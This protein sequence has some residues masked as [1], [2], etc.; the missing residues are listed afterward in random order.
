M[1]TV[2]SWQFSKLYSLYNNSYFWSLF[3]W[4]KT[5]NTCVHIQVAQIYQSI[6][7]SR[8][9][10]LVPF[11]DAFQLE[12]NI[13]DAARH[14]DLQVSS[15]VI[16]VYESCMDSCVLYWMK[17]IWLTLNPRKTI[18]SDSWRLTRLK[19]DNILRTDDYLHFDVWFWFRSTTINVKSSRSKKLKWNLLKLALWA[20]VIESSISWSKSNK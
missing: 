13:V 14:C 12:R 5:P 17:A 9:A 4:R 8:L 20:P 11:V 15:S 3:Y 10:T 2:I 16:H 19:G 7:F 6:E 18:G 1:Y